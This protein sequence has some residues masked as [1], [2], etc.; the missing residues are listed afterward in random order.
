MPGN[1]KHILVSLLGRTPQILTETL[2]MLRVKMNVPISE[3]FVFTTS[4]GKKAIYEHL[5]TPETGQFFRFCQDYHIDPK[6]IKFDENTIYV[7][8]DIDDLPISSSQQWEPIADVMLKVIRQLT[9]DADTI[10]HCSLA[11]GRKTMSVSLAFVIQ[12]FGRKQDRLYHVLTQ[13]TEFQN[14]PDFYYIPPQPR[15]I[16]LANG[17]SLS[18]LDAKIEIFDVPYIRLRKKMSADLT[19]EQL[20]F[21]ELVLLTQAE[22]EQ[23]PDV[24]AVVIDP[25]NQKIII[26][27]IKI[28]LTPIEMALYLYYAERSLA[29]DNAIPVHEYERYFEA[30]EGIHFPEAGLNRLL[31]IYRKLVSQFTLEQFKKR[32]SKDDLEF[33][34]VLQFIS[35]IK[36]KIRKALADDLLSQF[37]MIS[38]VGRYHKCY[39]IKLD[40]SKITIIQY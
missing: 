13:P 39:G 22:I 18:T 9:M 12:F 30:T 11:G 3:I 31:N 38:A 2:Y 14:H 35:R 29:R 7:A 36:N 19:H 20:K 34:Y 4:E 27:N 10:L 17:R 32:I 21:N 15:N 16:L 25:Q 5:L 28:H 33:E 6:T 26:G 24:T 37:Y 1:K 8:H 23:L 40:K